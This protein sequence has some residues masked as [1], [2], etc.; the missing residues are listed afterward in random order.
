MAIYLST[1]L[2]EK[3]TESLIEGGYAADTPAAIVY[4]ATWPQEEAY[5]CTVATLERTARE[6]NITKTAIVLVGDVIAH[7]HYEKSRLY[8]PDFSTEYRKASVE[9]KDND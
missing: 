4:K 3:L 1:G 9:S 8:A 2:L 5:V 7:R 6:H